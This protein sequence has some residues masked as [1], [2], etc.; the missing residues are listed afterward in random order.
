TVFEGELAGMLL[1]L[2]IVRTLPLSTHRATILLDNQAAVKAVR[3]RRNRPGQY[4]VDAFHREVTS[5]MR[6]RHAFRLH[7]AWVPGHMDVAGNELADTH[8]KLAAEEDETEHGITAL[9]DA[10]PRSA[11]AVKAAY[12]HSVAAQ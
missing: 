6:R 3:A 5:L 1:A 10:L 7:I 12:K 8:A 2:D 11:A 4:L 9:Q